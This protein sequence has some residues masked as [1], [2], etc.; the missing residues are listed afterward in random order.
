[1]SIV[2]LLA[3]LGC[4]ALLA[5]VTLGLL[6]G[7]L[8]TPVLIDGAHAVARGAAAILVVA[9]LLGWGTGLPA[10]EPVTG[11]VQEEAIEGPVL[12]LLLMAALAVPLRVEGSERASWS[13][14]VLYVPGWLLAVMALVLMVSPGRGVDGAD[15]VTPIRFSLAVCGGIAGRAGGEALQTLLTGQRTV[16][17]PGTLTYGLLT[18]VCGAAG[19]AAV[20]QRGALW[21]G[22]DPVLRGGMAGAWLTWTADWAMPRRY[23]RVAA[24]L[25]V[26]AVLLLIVVS[27]R[28]A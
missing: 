1:V 28:P 5:S 13:S 4:G 9:A 6:G 21:V 24:A 26:A 11:S 3:G 18:L 7:L 25:T 2:A 20:W 17:W 19:L 14:S 22:S 23:T 10:L 15:W 27:V 8:E 16:A 12:S